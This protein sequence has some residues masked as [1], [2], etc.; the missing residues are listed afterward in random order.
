MTP[1]FRGLS[2]IWPPLRTTDNSVIDA[3]SGNVALTAIL[4]M[5]PSRLPQ[6]ND[7][8][9]GDANYAGAR[10]HDRDPHAAGFDWDR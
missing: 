7:L 4:L 5:P 1:S 3:T 2:D 10:P 9:V 6:G 8:V